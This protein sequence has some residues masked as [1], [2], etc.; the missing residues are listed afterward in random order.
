MTSD[1]ELAG[2]L[3]TVS[4]R[5]AR[6]LRRNDNSGLT[7]GMLSVLG[8]VFREGPQRMSDL[9][10]REGVAGPTMTRLVDGLVGRGL[11]ERVLDA[12]DARIVR[13]AAT[14]LGDKQIRVSREEREGALAER[15]AS[16]TVA[17]RAAIRRALPALEKL[18]A[19]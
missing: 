2:E 4:G 19:E 7:A 9:A 3:R 16:L 5:L 12:D 10:L 18:A 17:E 8:L 1:A 13:V 15:L 6:W 11:V 14:P